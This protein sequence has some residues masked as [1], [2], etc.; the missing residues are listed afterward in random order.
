MFDARIFLPDLAAARKVLAE[1]DSIFKGEYL[2]RDEI[3]QLKDRSEG[4]QE[5]FLR[6]RSVPLNIWDEKPF[7]VALKR[8]ELRDVGKRSSIPAKAQFDTEAEAREFIRQNY[9]LQFEF[10]YGFDR[11]GWQYDL[12]EDQV[13][14]EDI[15]GH[16]S[17]EFKSPTEE[18]LRRLMA[19]FGA[20]DAIRGPSVVAVRQL[21]GR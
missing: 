12:G 21:L 13:D 15:E 11:R 1:S 4:I 5:V 2:I 10:L 20:T 17:I 19:K 16:P 6:L 18:G 14:L 3:F 8:T 7:I 9:D